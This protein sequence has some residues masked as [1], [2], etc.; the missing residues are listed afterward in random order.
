[1]DENTLR[2]NFDINE[3]HFL[4]IIDFLEFNKDVKCDLERFFNSAILSNESNAK[5]KI[6]ILYN[7]AISAGGGN[8]LTKNGESCKKF[9]SSLSSL[10]EDLQIELKDFYNCF[11]STINSFASL[12]SYICKKCLN[13]GPKK[14]ALFLKN[15]DWIQNHIDPKQKIFNN[16]N[17]DIKDLMIPVDNVIVT[18]LNKILFPS[19]SN[20]LDQYEDFKLINEFFKEKLND[21]FML[22][23]D[24]WFWGY[25]STMGNRKN[26]IIKFN[27]D[28][29]YTT[30]FLIPSV[31]NMKKIEEFIKILEK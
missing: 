20:Q 18:I 14:S 11:D 2:E 25:F 5:E 13:F 22:I 29:F 9:Y 10:G 19:N 30:D 28:K 3:K 31:S 4:K 27:M 16:Y 21:R 12:F 17:V 7:N 24:L 1:M 6:R 15:I 23:E 26:R 8:S